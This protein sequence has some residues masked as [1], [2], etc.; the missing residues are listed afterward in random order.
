MTFDR[1]VR[2]YLERYGEPEASL[3]DALEGPFGNVLVLPIYGE[4]ALLRA[5]LTSIPASPAGEVLIVA[6]VNARQNSPEWVHAANASTLGWLRSHF[7]N[8]TTYASGAQLFA[9][10]RGKLLLVDRAQ[11]GRYLP[12][13]Q[14]VGLARKIGSDLALG[15]ALRGGLRT[16]WLHWSD[17]DARLP[18]DYFERSHAR[19]FSRTAALLYPFRH[20]GDPA[21]PDGRA[22]YEYE[23]SLRYYVLGLRYAGSPYAFHT[24]G[25]TLA[26]D[27]AAYA[28]VRGVPR[29]VAGEDFYLLNKLAKVG[30]VRALSGEP[31]ALSGRISDRVPFGTGRAVG[32]GVEWIEQGGT[33]PTYHPVLFAYLRVWLRSLGELAEG[34]HGPD[35]RA[36][37]VAHAR[38]AAELDAGLLVKALEELGAFAA[39]LHATERRSSPQTL[40][41]HFD[42][43]FDA[44]FCVKL[45]HALRE[46][47]P[48]LPLAEALERAPFVDVRSASRGSYASYTGLDVQALCRELAKQESR[49]S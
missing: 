46:Q 32:R 49:T 16:R 24:I 12:E 19:P 48:S 39:A 40:R 22:V 13:G 29:R 11:H 25:S 31:V 45:L 28:R 38:D 8:G 34:Q 21:R 41:K 20:L 2:K 7:G 14:G 5:L 30:G 10:P 3:A 1:K 33:R 36:L 9:H 23:A 17:A 42:D 4:E 43:H 27:L 44:F 26:V 6:V 37:V 35:L 15:I 18:D 47:Y